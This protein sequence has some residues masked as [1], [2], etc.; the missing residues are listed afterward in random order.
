MNIYVGHEG[1]D[2]ET[3]ESIGPEIYLR[4]G[5]QFREVSEYLMDFP[6]KAGG[7]LSPF[8]I[9]LARQV[10]KHGPGSGYP[11]PWAKEEKGG[12]HVEGTPIEYCRDANPIF[13][14]P[15]CRG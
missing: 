3:G 15:L 2:K 1:K 4:P 11:T 14:A 6:T 13:P 8:M 5:K 7:K 12:Y 10:T 9:E